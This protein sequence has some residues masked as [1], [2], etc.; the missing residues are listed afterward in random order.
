MQLIPN[1]TNHPRH[2][3]RTYA[4]SRSFP[5][6]AQ[7]PT[8][9]SSPLLPEWQEIFD[10]LTKEAFNC[11]C[12]SSECR[13]FKDYF[14]EPVPGTS[15]HR[16][17][18]SR[19]LLAECPDEFQ[20]GLTLRK[21]RITPY[22]RCPALT[23]LS[24]EVAA[25]ANRSAPCNM[26]GPDALTAADYVIEK[27][28]GPTGNLLNNYP[29]PIWVPAHPVHFQ[30][31]DRARPDLDHFPAGDHPTILDHPALD[32]NRAASTPFARVVNAVLGRGAAFPSMG[33]APPVTAQRQAVEKNPGPTDNYRRLGAMPNTDQSSVLKSIVNREG[34]SEKWNTDF[35][36]ALLS[37]FDVSE[38]HPACHLRPP[39]YYI[40][41]RATASTTIT[42]AAENYLC[43]ML[44]PMIFTSDSSAKHVA[45]LYTTAT[46]GTSNHP[47][48]A[49]QVEIPWTVDP[50]SIV[51]LGSGNAT[52]A[53]L[54]GGMR[55]KAH[56]PYNTMQSSRV[57][58]T[59]LRGHH[60]GSRAHSSGEPV[61]SETYNARPRD[62][63]NSFEGNKPSIF[64]SAT[65]AYEYNHHPGDN[66]AYVTYGAFWPSGQ[67]SPFAYFKPSH[68]S[69]IQSATMQKIWQYHDS[70]FIE[71]FTTGGTCTVDIEIVQ[72]YAVLPETY[73][74]TSVCLL[75]TSAEA[76]SML[77]LET[78]F[79]TGATDVN[80]SR[81]HQQ[82][83]GFATMAL[84]EKIAVPAPPKAA[85]RTNVGGNLLGRVN[86]SHNMQPQSV[87]GSTLAAGATYLHPALGAGVK[88]LD[89]INDRTGLIDRAA[90]LVV[91]RARRALSSTPPP[92]SM[93][94]VPRRRMARQSRTTR[95]PI[96]T[97]RQPRPARRQSV[98]R[99]TRKAN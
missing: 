82:A 16:D 49:S 38:V 46:S 54:C 4:K 34:R 58:A 66:H 73:A 39:R 91:A 10:N 74:Q 65:G 12:G 24:E 99:R 87:L 81:A 23:A 40:P 42:L 13:G 11:P 79:Q 43:V 75:E 80:P 50:S 18:C 37:P 19:T 69:N 63:F 83:R 27:N 21:L 36:H 78:G 7:A 35:A 28:P 44:A 3:A 68:G 93:Y 95:R 2:Q 57:Y 56:G 5:P 31:R 64:G 22:T 30:Q 29:D 9:A 45:A 55:I 60:S 20:R 89:F 48:V 41:F 71:V 32:D 86:Q 84:S 61:Q 14:R 72:H 88:A 96:V 15:S 76:E 85:S 92:P 62:V 47:G 8:S 51:G 70:P 67:T 17:C 33:S 77:F 26:D 6:P 25:L 53:F 97:R 98:S 1:H 94:L 52:M 90:E 59:T